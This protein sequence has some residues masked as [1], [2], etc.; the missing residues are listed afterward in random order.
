MT[1]SKDKREGWLR[2]LKTG[3]EVIWVGNTWNPNRIKVI[4]NITPS[5]Q[6]D[7][8]SV[9]VRPN[10]QRLDL[11]QCTPLA[12]KGVLEQEEAGK[13]IVR[14]RE[15]AGKGQFQLEILQKVDALIT[16]EEIKIANK[17]K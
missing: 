10:N 4:T 2:K 6:I 11:K 12:R 7:L 3:D 8:G 14:I 16:E 9:R 15:W 13:L 1:N 17:G 5:G